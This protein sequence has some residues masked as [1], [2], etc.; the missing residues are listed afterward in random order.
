MVAHYPGRL[1][2]GTKFDSSVDRGQPFKF[3]LGVGQ[4]IPAWD[5]AFAQVRACV[6]D[7]LPRRPCLV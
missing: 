6:P 5:I 3:K 7:M 2:D 1:A 4:V